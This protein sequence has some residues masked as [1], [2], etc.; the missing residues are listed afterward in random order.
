VK[1][2]PAKVSFGSSGNY[3]TMHVP[4]DPRAVQALTS[5]GTSFQAQDTPDF[6]RFVQAD[7]R[8]MATLVQRIGKVD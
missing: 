6:E 7:A 2:H 5:A 1:S 3:G 4:M 8:A